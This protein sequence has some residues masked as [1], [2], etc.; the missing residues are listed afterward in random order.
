MAY[1]PLNFQEKLIK[2]VKNKNGLVCAPTNSGKTIVAYEWSDV[3]NRLND[4]TFRKII[5]TSPIKALSNE[6]YR[7]LKEENVDVGLITGDVKWNVDAKVLCMTQEI[8]SLGFYNEPCD[9]IIDEF[10]YIFQNEDR[11]RCYIESIDK[12]NANSRILLMSATC[13]QPEKLAKYLRSLTNRKFTVA[14][15]NKRLVPL[16][17]DLKG[18]NLKDIKDAIIFAFSVKDIDTLVRQLIDIKSKINKYT[19]DKINSL[20]IRNKVKYRRCWDYGIS[21]YYGKMLPKEKRFIEYIYSRGYIDIVVGTDALSLGVNF[22]AKTVVLST[23]HRPTKNLLEISEFQQ[24]TGRAGRYNYHDIG[25]ATFLKDSP[26]D[27][28]KDVEDKFKLYTKAKLE[29]VRIKTEVDIKALFNGRSN[30]E[31]A[32]LLLRYRYP[33]EDKKPERLLK[34]YLDEVDYYMTQI[35]AFCNKTELDLDNSETYDKW[36]R[37]MQN[38]YLHEWELEDNVKFIVDSAIQIVK[39]GYVNV[40][41]IL[42]NK[43]LVNQAYTYIGEYLRD[44]LFIMKYANNLKDFSVD[45]RGLNILKNEINAIDHTI[46]NPNSFVE[47]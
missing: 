14:E 10:H 47:D 26:V 23:M 13:K 38:C 11:A 46:F 43:D 19:I 4:Y 45:V 24:L 3:F 25:I 39:N 40:E 34:R 18:V 2:K 44:L 29:D 21:D 35:K 31:E 5:F 36:K 15:T 42:T 37:L 27:V 7:K 16:E 41:K 33:I 32:E 12:T 8:Y 20:A 17:Y 30:E 1:E 9:V 22:P 28:F 6:R